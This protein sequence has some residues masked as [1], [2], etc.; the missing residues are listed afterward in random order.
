MNDS[1]DRIFGYSCHWGQNQN[2]S[3]QIISLDPGFALQ[4]GL[5]HIGQLFYRK[6]MPPSRGTTKRS[7]CKE[8]AHSLLG[9]SWR[10][11]ERCLSSARP[12]PLRGSQTFW[13]ALPEP[14]P[15]LAFA[16]PSPR[17]ERRLGLPCKVQ[18][19]TPEDP[20]LTR[21]AVKQQSGSWDYLRFWIWIIY[22]EY[23]T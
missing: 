6:G 21:A 9:V 8:P 19:L 5:T 11:W 7:S 4:Q 16:S 14:R 10:L 20:N 3:Q 2:G 13:T 1:H 18:L 17:S 23:R 15:R 22:K 12:N